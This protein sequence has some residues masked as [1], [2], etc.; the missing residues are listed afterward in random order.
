MVENRLWISDTRRPHGRSGSEEASRRRLPP[1]QRAL[2]D[3]R[4]RREHQRPHPRL[5]PLP[6]HRHRRH[7][8]RHGDR[9]HRRDGSGGQPGRRLRLEA[10]EGVPLACRRLRHVSR[11]PRRGAH[12]LDGHHGVRHLRRDAPPHDGAGPTP[13]SCSSPTT[14][15]PRPARRSSKHTTAPRSSRTPRRR[16]STAACSAASRISTSEHAPPS[17]GD[18]LTAVGTRTPA[19]TPTRGPNCPGRRTRPCRGGRR[20]ATVQPDIHAGTPSRA[21]SRRGRRR[22]ERRHRDTRHEQPSGALPGLPGA[23]DP[24][25]DELRSQEKVVHSRAERPAATSPAPGVRIAPAPN[26]R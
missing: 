22:D 10:V 19:R 3:V 7:I 16:I 18:W 4:I 1:G 24:E 9:E 26:G 6:V 20:P 14:G 21:T 2:A 8:P 25:D 17:D 15:S 12:A 5:R 11:R 13:A 23:R